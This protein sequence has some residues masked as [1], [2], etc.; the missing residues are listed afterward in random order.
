VSQWRAR[1]ELPVA[2]TSPA[3]ARRVVEELLFAWKLQQFTDAT[4]LIA[5]ELVTNVYVHTPDAD[6]IEFELLG[7]ADRVRVSVADGSTIKPVIRELDPSSPTGRGMQLVQALSSRWGAEEFEG[8][9]RVWVEV[10]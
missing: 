7:Y 6:S 4:R 3:V 1:I 10:G 8:G 9:K 5:S 2:P